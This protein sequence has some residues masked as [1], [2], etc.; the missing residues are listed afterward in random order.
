VT[1]MSSETH[2]TIKAVGLAKLFLW[3]EA[4]RI[5]TYPQAF[6]NLTAGRV[7]TKRDI[8]TD[9]FGLVYKDG[10]ASKPVRGNQIENCFGMEVISG[11]KVVVRGINALRQV[12]SDQ[13]EA[14]EAALA[15]GQAYT[16][17]P[18]DEH[19]W[20]IPL[21][22]EMARYE[23]RTRL[24]LYLLGR[25]EWSLSFTTPEF[26]AFPSVSA[27]LVRE[28]ES[29]ALFGNNGQVFNRLLHEH[30][31]VALGPWWEAEFAQ[32]GYALSEEFHFEGIRGGPPS[33]NKLNSNLKSS[34]FLMK[35]L[36]VLESCHGGWVINNNQAA[37]VLGE[38]IARDSVET[39]DTE[40]AE[41]PL[42]SLKHLVD[43]LQDGAGLIV[44]S[45]L[46]WRWTARNH[47]PPRE[48]EA[49]F[50]QF[51]RQQIYEGTIRVVARHQGQPR[52]GRGLF[53]DGNARKIKLEFTG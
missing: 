37:A 13:F 46:A 36:G 8:A 19:S 5:Q 26:Y 3:P 38:A 25:G 6:A 35:Y 28:D 53:G 12:G 29:L 23:V 18:D 15:I 17:N 42:A 4:E 49:A 40:Q 24:L 52:H 14:S 21:A 43:E 39:P 11:E 48:A 51:M 16:R 33:T 31:R 32:A 27:T 22:R 41:S 50:D 20:A 1:E 30:R 9:V 44:V 47:V 2:Q 34:L 7:Y 10:E 45:D